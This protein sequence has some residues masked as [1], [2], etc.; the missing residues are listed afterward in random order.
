MF[1]LGIL[2]YAYMCTYH[3]YHSR[4]CFSIMH[5]NYTVCVWMPETKEKKLWMISV[6]SMYG[7]HVFIFRI[8]LQL[9]LHGI[10]P[11]SECVT[12]IST[13]II[14]MYA[15]VLCNSYWRI[16]FAWF[17]FLPLNVDADVKWCRICVRSQNWLGKNWDAQ[18]IFHDYYYREYN[19][20]R[21]KE[22]WIEKIPLLGEGWR[23]DRKG[24][25]L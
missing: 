12:H 15:Q 6:L 14:C 18:A 3:Y 17:N 16:V 8:T 11:K 2:H 13:D 9:Q 1:T 7:M 21:E 10:D 5:N 19:R 4:Q 25:C 23:G 24:G 22:E 20:Y